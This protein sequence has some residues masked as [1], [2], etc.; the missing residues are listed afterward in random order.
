VA[1]L[2]W[3]QNKPR[4]TREKNFFEAEKNFSPVDTKSL[5]KII[6]NRKY[7]SYTAQREIHVR[8]FIDTP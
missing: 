5:L 6:A 4:F 3:N 2:F 7:G 1:K 8:I